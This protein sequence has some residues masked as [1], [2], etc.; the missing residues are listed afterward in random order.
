MLPRRSKCPS[1]RVLGPKT[2]TLN[3][4]GF[5]DFA[6]LLNYDLGSLDPWATKQPS[7]SATA[8]LSRWKLAKALV[9][10]G[11][12]LTC[13]LCL[14]LGVE[15]VVSTYSFLGVT[16]FGST[17]SLHLRSLV[18]LPYKKNANLAQEL[19]SFLAD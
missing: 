9:D 13:E 7:P 3:G 1:S 12:G 15:G 4:F 17:H 14:V 8:V 5:W 16:L 11:L 18:V 10:W 6:T 19:P 2:H